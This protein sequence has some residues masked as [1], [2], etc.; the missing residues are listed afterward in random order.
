MDNADSPPHDR[1]NPSSFTPED[2]QP[3]ASSSQ[4]VGGSSFG[5]KKINSLNIAIVCFKHK[6]CIYASKEP[7]SVC[8]CTV[9]AEFSL[10][11]SEH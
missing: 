11:S 10:F 6:L 7:Y 2:S 5:E 9:P 1:E 8:T 4:S 3:R